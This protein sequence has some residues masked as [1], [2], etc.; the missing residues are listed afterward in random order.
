MERDLAVDG[1]GVQRTE[2]GAVR[3]GALHAGCSRGLLVS[4]PLH[5]GGRSTVFGIHADV[6]LVVVAAWNHRP[7]FVAEDAVVQV[8]LRVGE[9][10]GECVGKHEEGEEHCGCHSSSVREGL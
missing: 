1:D 4:A 10:S 6:G 8:W 7:G 3:H 2:R 5:G 9:F